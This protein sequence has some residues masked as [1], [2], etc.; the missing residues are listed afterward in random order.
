VGVYSTVTIS[1]SK[2][3]A[4]W[5]KR[6]GDPTNEE[7]ERFMDD[8]LEPRLLNA[9]VVPDASDDECDGDVIVE[10]ML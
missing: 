4:L 3:L 8:E 10:G 5:A 1:R 2:A 6:R 7:L 9:L